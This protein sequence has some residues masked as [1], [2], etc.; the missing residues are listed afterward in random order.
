MNNIFTCLSL[1]L[2]SL[3]STIFVQDAETKQQP[4]PVTQE[5][6]AEQPIPAAGMKAQQEDAEP[7]TDPKSEKAKPKDVT[8]L[9][10]GYN[11]TEKFAGPPTQFRS[12]HATARKID[13]TALVETE[14][15][16]QIQLKSKAPIPT[17]TFYNDRIYASGGFHSKE[18][19][20]FNAVSGNMVWGVDL[21]DDG[22]S[23]A[24]CEDNI[25][26]FNT[27]S[28]TIFAL[29]AS[30]GEMIWS[31]WLGDPLMSTP[32]IANGKVF[33]SYPASGRFDGDGGGRAGLQQNLHSNIVPDINQNDGQTA[34]K[35][36]G[37]DDGV[38][39]A[40][41][42]LSPPRGQTHVLACFDLKTGKILWQRWIDSDVMS[43]PIAVKDE[44][45]ATSF[46]GTLYKFK[47]SDGAIISATKMRA[48]AA[49]TI[50]D[51]KVV[52]PQ[53]ADEEG[54]SAAEITS[55]FDSSKPTA[56]ILKSAKRKADWLNQKVQAESALA[57]DSAQLDA[58]NGFAGGA[59]GQANPEA[60]MANIGQ[61]N[62]SSLQAYQGSRNLYARG[63]YYS[64]PGDELVCTN[65]AGKQLWSIKLEG[66]L[67]KVGGML[68]AP[69]ISAGGKLL[70]STI[71]GEV[72]Q[73][74]TEDGKIDKKFK[75][76]SQMRFPPIVDNGR[77]YVGTQDGKVVC[78]NSGDQS[79]TGWTTW[80]GNSAHNKT[81]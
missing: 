81:Q 44:L 38:K 63:N 73:L 23:A 75:V 60:A 11:D 71:S 50:V 49:P 5:Q 3:I 74:D 43:A 35:K 47:Q 46:G 36:V 39:K 30:S 37:Q 22:P 64:C 27:E 4:E 69:P 15:G 80:G 24:V 6:T 14:T 25:C 18:F 19:Y 12:G 56:P 48:T 62:V 67:K 72:W 77:I 33:T 58:G 41:N 76:G 78:I 21:D 20:C 13:D 79:L 16:F 32:T 53:R 70:V 68:A 29:D 17:I 51:G 7:K 8:E 54:E 55:T 2:I 42:K 40:K 28:C 59:P 31:K 34:E 65:Q 52:V 57:K 61:R 66:D 45:Y 9:V 10:R 26:V 1:L